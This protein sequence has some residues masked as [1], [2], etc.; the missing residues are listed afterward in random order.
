MSIRGW[1]LGFGGSIAMLAAGGPTGLMAQEPAPPPP[2][3][4]PGITA[5]DP[6]PMA[7]VSCHVVLPDGRDV[8]LSTLT[9]QWMVGV[10]S[11]LLAAA[12]SAAPTGM[13][14]KGRH[15]DAS[16]ALSNTPAGC[17][18]CHARNS[19]MAP[20][21]GRL[22]HRIHLTG[23]Q[24]NLYLTMFQGECTYCHK[25]DPTTGAWSIPSGPEP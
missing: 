13:T 5:E 22:L 4:T 10:D 20:P 3:A 1:F 12:Q 6:F 16:S 19:T 18:T 9:R 25:L 24:T 8:R 21:F 15:P 17:L 23:G 2:R 11:L 7:C 14:L